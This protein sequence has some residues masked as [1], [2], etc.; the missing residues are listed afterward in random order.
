MEGEE[1]ARPQENATENAAK[2]LYP[3][4][5]EM[6]LHK[7]TDSP[8]DVKEKALAKLILDLPEPT[9]NLL[10][11]AVGL[12]GDMARTDEQ[13]RYMSASISIFFFF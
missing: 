10:K 13:K 4:A 9:P 2:N 5:V 6:L 11:A 7:I 8:P 3:T 12:L 1:E